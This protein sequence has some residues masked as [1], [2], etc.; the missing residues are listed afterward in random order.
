MAGNEAQIDKGILR[1]VGDSFPELKEAE[2]DTGISKGTYSTTYNKGGTAIF[3]ERRVF[4]I[5][6]PQVSLEVEIGDMP[7]RR[8][9]IAGVQEDPGDRL[10]QRCR[11]RH[12]YL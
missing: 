6:L 5:Q 7:P 12:L 1:M 3:Q 9:A 8:P 2:S 10:T 11:L 4:K